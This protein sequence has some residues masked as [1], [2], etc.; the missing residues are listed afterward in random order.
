MSSMLERYLGEVVSTRMLEY[1]CLKFQLS[2][3][4]IRRGRVGSLHDAGGE[5]LILGGGR[6]G[7][8]C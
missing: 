6:E 7:C 4:L 8:S 2:G 1:F 5:G 3:P